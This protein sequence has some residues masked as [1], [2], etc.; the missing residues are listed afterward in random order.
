MDTPQHIHKQLL[1]KNYAGSFGGAYCSYYALAEAT[2]KREIQ[3]NVTDMHRCPIEVQPQESWAE[4][5]TIDPYGMCKECPTIAATKTKM[6]VPELFGLEK[7]GKIVNED[8]SVNCI[9][10]AL[11]QVW[12]L[13]GIAKRLK[14]EEAELRKCLFKQL[15]NP[16]L[17][18]ESKSVY[19]PPTGGSTIYI[20][21][22]YSK[23]ALETKKVACRVHDECN[24]S[25]TFG[26]HICSCRPYLMY[27][28]KECVKFAQEGNLGVVVY[29]RKEGR[30]L[31]EV[32]KYLVYNGRK[33]QEGG[34][35]E[36]TYFSSTE[37]FANVR[38]ARMQPLMPDPLLW[39]GLT[40]IDTWLSMSNEKSDALKQCGIEI[41]EQR[42]VPIEILPEESM[43]E[44]RA[45]IKDGYYSK[46]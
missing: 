16:D 6:T 41:V 39:L 20:F 33:N 3:R 4:I 34:D 21:G 15:N 22:D 32:I 46:D 14:I 24:G 2:Y 26:T 17:M 7:D 18:D 43:I 8:G 38:D 1:D 42:E 28:V 30:S 19:L 45:K 11:E 25:D 13:P 31:G 10:I 44:L 37:H 29:N 35:R 12:H 9:K 40:R 5:C 27:A 23:E 36:E